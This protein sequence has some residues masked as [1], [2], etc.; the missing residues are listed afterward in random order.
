MHL[1]LDTQTTR[2]FMLTTDA[3]GIAVGAVLSQGATGRGLGVKQFRPYLWGRRFQV[4]TDHK[5]LEWV[6][7]LKENSARVTRWKKTLA[8]YD[9]DIGHTRGAENVETPRGEAQQPS[10]DHTLLNDKW[11]QVVLETGTGQLD[12]LY[13]TGSVE[14]TRWKGALIGVRTVTDVTEQEQIVREYQTMVRQTTGRHGGDETS[15]EP[16]LLVGDA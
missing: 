4:R 6:D 11:L 8:A 7:R 16:A 3:S 5:S 1:Y 9:F 12:R 14:G 13:A 2:E 10:W 15:E